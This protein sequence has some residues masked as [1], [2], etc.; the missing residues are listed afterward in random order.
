MFSSSWLG[1]FWD[2]VGSWDKRWDRSSDLLQSIVRRPSGWLRLYLWFTL[3]AKYIIAI[4]DV[5]LRMFVGSFFGLSDGVGAAVG[6]NVGVA[7]SAHVARRQV[8]AGNRINFAKSTQSSR[9]ANNN[10]QW[11][12]LCY[13]IIHIASEPSI[14]AVT[15]L[16]VSTVLLCWHKLLA[17]DF[18]AWMM[19]IWFRITVR[20]SMLKYLFV[21]S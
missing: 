18:K 14:F 1:Y 10:P 19:L 15:S 12:K 9:N 20:S 11:P 2:W 7:R 8:P 13:H 17:S 5:L 6:S 4:N 16:N 21:S 3:C